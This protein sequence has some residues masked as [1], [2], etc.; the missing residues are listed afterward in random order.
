MKPFTPINIFCINKKLLIKEPYIVHGDR[1]I[2]GHGA[3]TLFGPNRDNLGPV[4]VPEGT[5]F[6]MGDNRDNSNDSRFWGFVPREFVKGEAV[7]ILW[8]AEQPCDWNAPLAKKMGCWIKSLF[9]FFTWT[10]WGRVLHFIN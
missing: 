8:S 1:Q 7:L 4:Y 2:F 3:P 10:R 6:V 9:H 5:F